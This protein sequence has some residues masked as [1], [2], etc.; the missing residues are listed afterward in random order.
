[1]SKTNPLYAA[2]ASYGFKT[3]GALCFGIWNG[4][5]VQLRPYSGANYYLDVAVRADKKDKALR[6]GIQKAVKDN[7]GKNLGCIN[8]GQFLSF[9]VNFRKKRSYEEQFSAYMSAILSA[10]R[11]HGIRPADSCAVCGGGSPDSLCLFS[12]SYQ[13]VHSRCIHNLA[14]QQ[15]EEAEDNRL[16]GSYFTGLF[17]ALLGMLVGLLPN[18]LT[19]ISMERIYALL[20]A[21]VP[22]AAAWGYRKFKGRMSK[23]SILIIVLLSFIGV[24]IMEYLVVLVSFIKD[25]GFSLE[26]ALWFSSDLLLTLDG[27]MILASN[28]VSL[29][30]FMALG[31]AFAWKYISQTNTSSLKQ[32]D[33]VL[34]TLQPNPAYA[35]D[36]VFSYQETDRQP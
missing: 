19:I 24:F 33:S 17:G 28:S 10:L 26:E 22:M 6:K 14:G 16:N 2:L 20:F 25:S 11:E 29:F 7:Y 21:L 34:A 5:A 30:L 23:A 32:L 13:P 12:H 35:A 4:Y 3:Q 18:V 31:I 27:L 8:N 36:S 9:T 1:M 15:K